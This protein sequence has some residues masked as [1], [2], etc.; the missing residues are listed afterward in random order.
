MRT[1][2]IGAAAVQYGMARSTIR[3]LCRQRRIDWYRPGG[4]RLLVDLDS[5]EAWVK[6]SA[7]APTT[8]RTVVAL[9]ARGNNNG[10]GT[11]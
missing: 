9:F 5:L 10:K 2:S 1:A 6:S 11:E 8:S 3:K 4:M 7:H